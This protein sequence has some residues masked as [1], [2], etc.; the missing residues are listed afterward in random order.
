[1]RPLT[2][3]W[4][5][6]GVAWFGVGC[7]LVLSLW[8]G[9]VPLPVHV[10]DKIEHA[11]GYFLL[12]GWFTGLYRRE[13]YPRLGLGCLLLGILIELLQG[14]TPTRSMELGDLAANGVGIVTAL[15]LAYLG[16]GAWAETLERVVVVGPRGLPG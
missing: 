5:W 16:L 2:F 9:G 15:A 12:T 11:V 3:R 1:M 13:R 14:L 4:F 6:L 7:A 10:W 8:P